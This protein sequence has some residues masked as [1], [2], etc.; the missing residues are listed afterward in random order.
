MGQEVVYPWGALCQVAQF[1]CEFLGL[2]HDECSTIFM[3]GCVDEVTDVADI[4][5]RDGDCELVCVEV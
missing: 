2:T 5:D 4:G 3:P 1:P